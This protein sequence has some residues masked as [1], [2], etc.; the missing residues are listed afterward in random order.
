LGGLEAIRRAS[1]EARPG[2][3]P[4]F[5]QYHIVRAILV[6]SRSPG[7]GRKKLA[8]ALGMGEGVARTLLSRLRAAGLVE[9][10][11][12][13][14]ILTEEARTLLESLL[15]RVTA[16]KPLE[17]RGTWPYIYSVGVLVKGAAAHVGK[18]IEQRDA[19][20]RAGARG[21][22][23]LVYSEGRLLMPRISDVSR[24]HPGFAK[25]IIEE[26]MPGEGDVVII[27]GADT[28]YEAENGAIAAALA[29]LE[30]ANDPA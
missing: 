5:S 18:G 12:A 24:E 17:L 27:A 14:C 26:M 6:L 2:P 9:T 15:S 3:Q 13:G 29:T 28:A 10:S 19:A 1:G 16:P 4:T 22:I 23:T 21:A 30:E 11:R 8:E 20:I 25:R 7:I